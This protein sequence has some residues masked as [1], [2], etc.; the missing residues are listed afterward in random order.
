M[1]DLMFSLN[2]VT[3]LFLIV[4]LGYVLKRRGFID[5]AFVNTATRVCFFVALPCMLFL[6][7]MQSDFGEAFDAPLTLLSV[8]GTLVSLALL[9]LFTP[10]FIKD[11]SVSSAF[12][13]TSFHANSVLLG[14]PLIY[15]LVGQPGL[16]KTAAVLI[17]MVPL[18]NILSVLILY[19]N[20]QHNSVKGLLLK[21]I[22]ANPLI[23][24]VV[25]GIVCSLARLRPPQLLITPLSYMSDMA[26]G[27]ALF[28]LGASVQFKKAG[29]KLR[30][31]LIS[32]LIKL[33]AIPVAAV[34]VACCLRFDP[35]QMAVTLAMFAGPPAVVCFPL[36]YQMGADHQFTSQAIVLGTAIAAL[37]MFGF[38]F[39]LRLLGF[40]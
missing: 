2:A 20:K 12:I 19:E 38:V 28:T 3:P 13:Q 35:V 17:F 26:M 21:K 8:G 4:L 31:A 32:S 25:L 24:A 1:E 15:N 37:T 7:I 23:I 39:V 22:A 14:L 6:T 33:I 16:T 18:L 10:F 11:I 5:D 34:A 9:R 29:A 36:A 30:L 40:V 27:L